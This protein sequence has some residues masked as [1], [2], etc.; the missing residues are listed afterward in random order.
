MQKFL[1]EY[2]KDHILFSGIDFT[3]VGIIDVFICRSFIR[4]LLWEK[5]GGL[6]EMP[7]GHSFLS[8]HS[9]E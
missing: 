8:L 5:G 7:I 4:S 2:M 9:N 1:N 6:L 3:A